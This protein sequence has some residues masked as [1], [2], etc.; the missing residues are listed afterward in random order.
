MSASDQQR[1]VDVRLLGAFE[2]EVDGTVHHIA[3]KN[4]IKLLV[5]LAA[6]KGQP[7]SRKRLR[8]LIWDTP[9]H[10]D[11]DLSSLMGS[12]RKRL[13]EF[14][15]PNALPSRKDGLCQLLIKPTS[16]DLHRFEER[17]KKAKATRNADSFRAAI[18]LFT[19]EPLAGLEGR[20]LG[21][22]SARWKQEYENARKT[23]IDIE[24]RSKNYSTTLVDL[25]E[26]LHQEPV[27]ETLAYQGMFVNAKL[28]KTDTALDIHHQISS[29]VRK[30]YGRPVRKELDDLRDQI[31]SGSLT[32]ELLP[33]YDNETGHKA[34]P[35]SDDDTTN[36]HRQSRTSTGNKLAA[37][38]GSIAIENLIYQPPED[39]IEDLIASRTTTTGHKV[40]LYGGFT[41]ENV[42]DHRKP[43]R[44]E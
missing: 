7:V 9:D 30:R 34:M 28:G 15:L 23:L 25:T 21:A 36:D 10:A 43:E 17:L 8:E 22:I 26:L 20:T 18:E 11:D 39:S 37:G 14:G 13:A 42:I 38:L 31:V 2:I 32:R 27:N 44:S 3:S 33:S 4:E 40:S 41:A 16:V 24:I 6:A 19:G 1:A 5:G 29:I 12:V 35:P